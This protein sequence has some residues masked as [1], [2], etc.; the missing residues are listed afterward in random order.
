LLVDGISLKN[1]TGQIFQIGEIKLEVTGE[2]RPCDVMEAACNGLSE[3]LKPAWR[4]GIMCRV[5][6]AGEIHVADKIKL[7]S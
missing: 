5:V 2:T 7:M 6:E 3:A 4:G 1:S